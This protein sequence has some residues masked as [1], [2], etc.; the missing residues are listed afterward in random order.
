M[1]STTADF[2]TRLF[3]DGK[4]VQGKGS[5]KVTCYNPTDGSVVSDNVHVASVQDVDDAVAAA[6]AAFPGWASTA[7]LAKS[8]LL[9]K[10][11]DLIEEQAGL[12]ARLESLCSGKPYKQTIVYEAPMAANIFRYYA[13]YTDKLEGESLPPDNGFLRI[14]Q[15]VPI[16]V[17]AAINAFN[18]GII[19]V[20]MKVA[21][22]LAAGNTIV[23]KGSEKSPLAVLAFGKLVEQAGFPPGTIN[24]IT[25]GP[26]TGSLLASHMD[27]DKIAFTGSV[28]VGKKVAQAAA[29]S[30]LKRVTLELGG[31]SPSIVFPDANLDVATQWCVQGIVGNSGQACIASSRVY[32]HRDIKEKF[33]DRMKQALDGTKGLMGKDVFAESTQLGPLVDRA[34]YERVSSFV[35]S[36]KQEATIVTG[37]ENPHGQGCWITPALFIDPK[38]DAKIYKEEIFGPVV[39]VSEFTDEAEVIKRANATEFGLSGAVFSQDINRAIRV[40]GQIHSG[41]VCIN[42]CTMFDHNV[43]FGG[44]KQSGWGR[45]LGKHGIMGYTEPKTLYVNMTY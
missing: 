35:E 26:E 14:I 8:K 38:P 12:F 11:A 33:V 7:P 27:I 29:A 28:G 16:G 36:G 42:C 5:P 1:G 17:C 22:A 41:A 32:V 43:A 44:M 39:V 21:P 40:A 20:S 24:L 2:E 23:I 18:G 10:I 13:G 37:G 34:H 9:N 25:G 6:R 45:E 31:K 30:N 3:I 4:Y 19:M 15:K